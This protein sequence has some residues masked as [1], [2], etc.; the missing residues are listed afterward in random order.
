MGEVYAKAASVIAWLGE[1]SNDSNLAFDALDALPTDSLQHWDPQ[2][3]VKLDITALEPKCTSAIRS[4]FLRPWWRRIWTVQES[5]LGPAM[6]LVCG[7]RQVTVDTLYSVA[8]SYVHHSSA[9]CHGFLVKHLNH[10][11]FYEKM[12]TPYG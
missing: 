10:G 8:S 1:E 12:I 2:E 11:E 3:N 4:L 9:C 6:S 7:K 5:I